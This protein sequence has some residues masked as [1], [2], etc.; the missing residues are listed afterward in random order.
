M[1]ANFEKL[2]ADRDE[3]VKRSK[4]RLANARKA[5]EKVHSEDPSTRVHIVVDDLKRLSE[6]DEGQGCSA[7]VTASFST[8]G[9][10]GR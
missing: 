4:R 7:C 9:A 6:T 10:I 2:A 1:S 5:G 8:I 3:A